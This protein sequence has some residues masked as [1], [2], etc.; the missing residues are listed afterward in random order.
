M[1]CYN[2]QNF[3]HVWDNCKQPPRCLFCGGGHLHR[4]CPE[5]TNTDSTPSC[6]NCT[7]V[8]G[9]KIIQ[10]HSEAA[11]MRKALRRDPLEGRSSLIL[12]QQSGPAQ[13]HCVKT[14]PAT[15]C[16]ADRW[17]KS[18]APRTA[19]CATRGNSDNRSVSSGS[20]LV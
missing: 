19:P 20:Q 12:P 10:R 1:Q 17:E 4:E 3:D 15:T 18:A 9:E 14:T 11:V 8:E 13:L 7:L 5:N 6:G 2:C 16:T